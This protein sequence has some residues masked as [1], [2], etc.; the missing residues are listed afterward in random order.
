MFPNVHGHRNINGQRFGSL[1]TILIKSRR[2]RPTFTS[3]KHSQRDNKLINGAR[4]E[5]RQRRTAKREQLRTEE[6]E[7][8]QQTP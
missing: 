1:C 8:K 2:V 7:M 3:L 6:Q 5:I 4:N